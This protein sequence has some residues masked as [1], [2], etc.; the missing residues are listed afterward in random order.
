MQYVLRIAQGT[1]GDV[2]PLHAFDFAKERL[3]LMEA[4][5]KTPL[6]P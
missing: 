5:F 1:A 4:F 6:R 2:F 3:Q